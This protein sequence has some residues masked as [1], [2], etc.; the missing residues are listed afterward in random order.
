VSDVT[1]LLQAA[2]RGERLASEELLPLVY[3]EL[4]RVALARIAQERPGQTLQATALVHEAW[5]EL[6][7]NKDSGWES[8]AHF[9]GAA[10]HA[11]RRILMLKA[12]RKSRIKHGGGQT[13]VDVGDVEIPATD[14][15]EKILLINEALERLEQEDPEQA[16]VVVLKF[17]GGLTNE[18]VAVN[19][20]ISPRS[21]D[22]QWACAKAWL[23]QWTRKQQ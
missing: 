16:R 19:L 3:E 20:G 5:L 2:G 14:A 21:V 8:R 22:R 6:V 9:F 15:D 12:R 11:M 13:R 1:L 4:R 7:G 10:A 18:Q 17:F 23:A